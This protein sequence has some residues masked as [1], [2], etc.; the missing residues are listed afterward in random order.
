MDWRPTL[1]GIYEISDSGEIRRTISKR[2]RRFAIDK[3]G[4]LTLPFR[5]EK[6]QWSEVYIHQLVAAAFLG[7]K[8]AGH[9]I[10]HK[11]GVKTDNRAENLE[12]VTHAENMA[13]AARNGLLPQSRRKMD[14]QE[15]K[16]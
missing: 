9:E 10:N 12:Y 16:P 11:N 15:V 14:R 8:P 2:V 3:D 1:F 13:H 7:P 4:Y 6:K 5:N